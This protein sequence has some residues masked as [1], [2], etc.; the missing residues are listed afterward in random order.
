MIEAIKEILQKNKDTLRG[1]LAVCMLVAGVL[2]FA[3]PDPFIKIVPGFMPYP[4][5]L[6]YI[7]GVFEIIFGIGLIVPATRSLSGLGLVALFIA[8]YPANLNMAFN[9]IKI[10]NIPD[11]WWLHGFRLPFQFVLI[12]WAAWYT[13]FFDKVFNKESR[14]S[15]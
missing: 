1:I 9:H 8:V 15:L 12:A 3:T 6:V 2:H 7:S 11:S 5:A 4:A 10:E 13:D 14:S